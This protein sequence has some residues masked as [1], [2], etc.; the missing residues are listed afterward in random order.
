MTLLDARR[1]VN[2]R[3]DLV[4]RYPTRSLGRH[5]LTPP[6]RRDAPVTK[7]PRRFARTIEGEVWASLVGD[8]KEMAS[9]LD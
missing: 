3:Y 9:G 5:S 7:A 2:L 4:P 8:G 6:S 1:A